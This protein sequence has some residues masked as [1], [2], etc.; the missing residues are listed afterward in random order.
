MHFKLGHYPVWTAPWI[1][2]SQLR[3]RRISNGS[4]PIL[5]L[6]QSP[7]ATTWV[8]LLRRQPFSHLLSL[9]PQVHSIQSIMLVFVVANV[10]S[11]IGELSTDGAMRKIV[12]CLLTH[13]EHQ[14]YLERFALETKSVDTAAAVCDW[15]ASYLQLGTDSFSQQGWKRRSIRQGLFREPAGWDREGMELSANLSDAACFLVG[16]GPFAV[17]SSSVRDLWSLTVADQAL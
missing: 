13:S 3:D 9:L 14:D 10:K 2:I 16:S 15:M 12:L 7:S 1:G 4:S 6:R 11:F 5:I 8:I 17:D